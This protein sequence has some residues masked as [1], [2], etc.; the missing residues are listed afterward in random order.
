MS[1]AQ[2]GNN[3][4]VYATASTAAEICSRVYLDKAALDLL[5]TGMSPRGFVDALVE[6][7]Q[8]LAGIDFMAHVLPSREAI[9][10]GCLCLHHTCGSKLEPWER[11]AYRLTVQ[12]VLQPTE[13]NRAANKQPA[14]VLGPASAAGCLAAAANQTGG[15]IGPPDGPPMPPSPLAPNRAVAIAV[16]VASTKV[17]A[18]EILR[19]QRSLIGLGMAVAEG[20]YAPQSSQS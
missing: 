8:Y 15:S 3:P 16:K 2:P 4:L 17:E 6:K 1:S 5:R 18:P 20:R 12:W 13:A 7:G 11:R 19:T 9:W 10:W 14:E